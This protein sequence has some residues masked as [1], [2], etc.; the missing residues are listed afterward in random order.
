[1]KKFEI[2]Y[3]KLDTNLPFTAHN[4]R[5]FKK[6]TDLARV[7]GNKG[8]FTCKSCRAN[9]ISKTHSNNKKKHLF[10]N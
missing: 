7:I 6:A 5:A 8:H 9:C 3:L 1:M 4:T 10:S 2:K